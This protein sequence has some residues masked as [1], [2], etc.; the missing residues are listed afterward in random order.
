V[1]GKLWLAATWVFEKVVMVVTWFVKNVIVRTVVLCYTWGVFEAIGY[2]LSF[3]CTHQGAISYR[4]GHSYGYLL[5]GLL[6]QLALF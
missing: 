5:V 4:D 3:S 2:I 1:L 6:T